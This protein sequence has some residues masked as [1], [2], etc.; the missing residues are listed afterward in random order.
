MAQ[1]KSV[2]RRTR[3]PAVQKAAAQNAKVCVWPTIEI[4]VY[5]L[6]AWSLLSLLLS[7]Y[8]LLSPTVLGIIGWVLSFAAFGYIGG[9]MKGC[10][11]KAAAKMGALAGLFVGCVNALLSVFSF[12]YYPQIFEQ[13][14]SEAI[15]QGVPAETAQ[16]FMMIGVYAGL[17][18]TPLIMA[19]IGALISIV[20]A[21]LMKN[22]ES[23]QS[24]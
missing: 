4:P 20:S 2:V 23:G 22:T 10:G 6:S 16:N 17:I 19:G 9:T 18:I 12:Y 8:Q 11:A 24:G 21:W 5:G 3:I 13:A 7:A 1:K 15:A 14:F